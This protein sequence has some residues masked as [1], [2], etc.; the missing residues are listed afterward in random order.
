MYRLIPLVVI[1]QQ[2]NYTLDFVKHMTFFFN[3]FSDLLRRL[4]KLNSI[5]S[6]SSYK[7]ICHSLLYSVRWC[8]FYVFI[9]TITGNETRSPDV[10]PLLRFYNSL[11]KIKV[12]AQS[13]CLMN[14]NIAVVH[15]PSDAK[16][17]CL[18]I[19]ERR[20]F[21]PRQVIETRETDCDASSPALAK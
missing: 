17:F 16:V 18:A 15:Y 5:L 6:C 14:T 3:N 9:R 7:K 8:S 19:D 11:D 1:I 13:T 21:V 2:A 12:E 4:L 10:Q 20:A